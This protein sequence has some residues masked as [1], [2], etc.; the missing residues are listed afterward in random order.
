MTHYRMAI[1]AGTIT[2]L[3]LGLAG[4]F[5]RALAG[6]ALLVPLLTALYLRDVNIHENEPWGVIIFT[7]GWGAVSAVP[8]RCWHGRSSR[9]GSTAWRPATRAAC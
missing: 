7:L 6:A 5:P 8:W 3:A 9:P 2:V 4:L 1:E